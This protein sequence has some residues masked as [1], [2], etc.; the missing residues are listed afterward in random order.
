[1]SG[2]IGDVALLQGALPNTGGVPTASVLSSLC[3]GTLTL[4]QWASINGLTVYSYYP[5]NNP[6]ASPPTSFA[7]DSSSTNT[8]IANASVFGTATSQIIPG[9]PL[10]RAPCLVLNEKG[11]F[12]VAPLDPGQSGS[13]VGTIRIS[14]S[15]S[16]SSCG[17]TV[18]GIDYNLYSVGTG[19]SVLAGWT[20]ATVSGSAFSALQDGIPG[21]TSGQASCYTVQVRIHN[22][23]SYSLGGAYPV[24]VG[25]SMLMWGQSQVAYMLSPGATGTGSQIQGNGTTAFQAMTLSGAKSFRTQS[26]TRTRTSSCWTPRTIPAGARRSRSPAM[27]RSRLRRICRRRSAASTSRS[28]RSQKPEMPA[29]AGRAIISPRRPGR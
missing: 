17:G 9:S 6:N 28:S 11:P 26:G 18:T 20:A 5:L 14:G 4:K 16:S 27:A 3:N 1:M 24:C 25:Y 19:N 21:S 2:P 15:F 10:T 12:D 22:D 29:T 13:G 8:S 23:T 7:Y